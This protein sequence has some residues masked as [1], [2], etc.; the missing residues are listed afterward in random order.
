MEL[1]EFINRVRGLHCLEGV[2]GM[3]S[4]RMEQFQHNPIRFLMRC[5]DAEADYI[6]RAVEARQRPTLAAGKM[7]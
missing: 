6:W 1:R 4:V 3:T 2:P 5:D 7:G